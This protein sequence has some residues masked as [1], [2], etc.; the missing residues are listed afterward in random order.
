MNLEFKHLLPT[1]SDPQSRVWIYQ[2]SR[3]FSMSEALHIEDRLQEFCAGWHTHGAK[4]KAY[5]NLFF[6][7]F[8]VLMAD[9]TGAVVSGCSTDSSVNF[10]KSLGQQF[11]VDFFNRTTLAFFIKDKIQ[12]LP[13]NQLQYAVDNDFITPNTLFFNN[14]AATKTDLE[15]TWIIPVKASWLSQKLKLK[16]VV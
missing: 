10:I 2:S 6:G 16:T 12:V 15:T 14:L 5:A 3:L 4:V 13:L 11:N 8:V 1:D 9:E 7:Q